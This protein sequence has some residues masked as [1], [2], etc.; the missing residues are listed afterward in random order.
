MIQTSP[1]EGG[2]GIAWNIG[3]ITYYSATLCLLK[4]QSLPTPPKISVS[5][6]PLHDRGQ[7]LSHHVLRQSTMHASLSASLQYDLQHADAR[8]TAYTLILAHLQ[9]RGYFVE[10]IIRCRH[11]CT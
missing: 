11:E 8:D 2:R 3:Q 1:G 4:R 9:A 6:R 10:F 7:A 5:C